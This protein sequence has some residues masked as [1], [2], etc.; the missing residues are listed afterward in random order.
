MIL[1]TEHVEKHSE[2]V[3]GGGVA[4]GEVERAEHRIGDLAVH[5]P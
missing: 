2:R 5:E 1:A 3:T 4:Y